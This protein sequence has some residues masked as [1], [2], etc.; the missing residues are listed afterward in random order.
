[1]EIIFFG[2]FIISLYL[3][4]GYVMALAVFDT[5]WAIFTWPLEWWRGTHE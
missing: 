3:G 2:I 1:M 5:W 4:I